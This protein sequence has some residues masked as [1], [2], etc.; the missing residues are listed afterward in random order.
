MGYGMAASLQDNIGW[1]WAFYIQAILLI[2][3]MIGLIFTPTKY[4]DL[5]EADKN[6]RM[7]KARQSNKVKEDV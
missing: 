4:F 5:E 1:R 6:R 3:S 7:K 2:P